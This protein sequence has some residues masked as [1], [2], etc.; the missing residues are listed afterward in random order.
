M[1][2]SFSVHRI[3]LTYLHCN[4]ITLFIF[5]LCGI[6]VIQGGFDMGTKHSFLTLIKYLAPLFVYIVGAWVISNWVANNLGDFY[7]TGALYGLVTF[8]I[9]GLL[10]PFKKIAEITLITNRK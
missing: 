9:C 4:T 6:I 1:L 10:Y 8:V 5:L 2:P 3:I 7:T